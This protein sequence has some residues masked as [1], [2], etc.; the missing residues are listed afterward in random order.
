MLD[1]TIQTEAKLALVYFKHNV[2]NQFSLLPQLVDVTYFR[3]AF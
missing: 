1:P 2:W 3:S